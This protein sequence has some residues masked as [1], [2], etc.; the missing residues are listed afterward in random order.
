MT[1][2]QTGQRCKGVEQRDSPEHPASSDSTKTS[3]RSVQLQGEGKV[4][5]QGLGS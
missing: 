4:L 3:L 2:F 5:T 1:G